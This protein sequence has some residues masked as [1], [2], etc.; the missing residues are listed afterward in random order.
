MG[1]V[2]G[3]VTSETP[4][5]EVLRTLP[6]Y[7]VRR[8]PPA[9]AAVYTHPAGAAGAG[10]SAGF[11]ALAGYYG[12]GSP[13]K[14]AGEPAPIA[15]TAPV[16]MSYA[17]AAL[18]PASAP[19]PT[20]DAAMTSMTFLL[21]AKYATAADAPVPAGDAVVL[22][23]VP[24]RTAAVRVFSGNL[25]LPAIREQVDALREALRRDGVNVPDGEEPR[26]A[27][28]NPPFTVPWLKTNEIQI[29]V[30]PQSLPP[31]EPAAPE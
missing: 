27:G 31:A 22:R 2:L 12:I 15:M 28:Y 8:F 13:P 30:D 24:A 7:E 6:G 3:R 26:V 4:A 14:Q 9:V 18:A 21:P 29:T 16:L 10:G 17:P 11:R 5:H 1:I 19:D 25:S 20:W 23:D